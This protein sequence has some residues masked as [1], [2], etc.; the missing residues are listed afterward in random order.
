MYVMPKAKDNLKHSSPNRNLQVSQSPTA[1]DN[2]EPGTVSV[3]QVIPDNQ[4]MVKSD[5]TPA[6]NRVDNNLSEW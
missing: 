6:D 5:N 1:Y 3:S 2:R 4:L